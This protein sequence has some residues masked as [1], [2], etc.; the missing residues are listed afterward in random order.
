MKMYILQIGVEDAR[1]CISSRQRLNKVQY[2]EAE[3]PA[4]VTCM[5]YQ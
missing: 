4:E 2:L 3:T 5:H 1:R